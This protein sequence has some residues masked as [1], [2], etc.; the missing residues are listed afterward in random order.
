MIDPELKEHLE[1]IENELI[2]MRKKSTSIK[3][4]LW[5]GVIYG[6]G[7]IIGVVLIIVVVGWVL[8]TLGFIPAVNRL[9]EE[10]SIALAK[11]SGR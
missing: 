4:S 3:H 2:H 11:Y 7:Y 1:K 6:A 8:N 10:L 5:L 9:A